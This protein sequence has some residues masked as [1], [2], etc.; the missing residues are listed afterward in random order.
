MKDNLKRA[1]TAEGLA[2][3]TMLSQMSEEIRHLAKLVGA[4]EGSVDEIIERF[5]GVLEPRIIR[6][7]QLIDVVGQTL[8]ALSSFTANVAKQADLDWRIDGASAAAGL[9]LAGLARRLTASGAA[10]S[11][12]PAQDGSGEFEFFG[13]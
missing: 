4:M 7:I 2:V 10:D 9:T 12:A 6:D 13:D 1:D 11:G 8:H 5:S 3:G